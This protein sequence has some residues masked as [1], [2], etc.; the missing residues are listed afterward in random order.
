M[1]HDCIAFNSDALIKNM[2]VKLP[3]RA[4][5][6]MGDDVRPGPFWSVHPEDVPALVKAGYTVRVP[7]PPEGKQ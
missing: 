5:M 2:L 3:G 1:Q 7:Y 6:H 4:V